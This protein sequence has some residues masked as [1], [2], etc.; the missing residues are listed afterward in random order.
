M[1]DVDAIEQHAPPAHVVEASDQRGQG[2]LSRAR[3][4]DERHRFTGADAQIQPAQQG[5]AFAIRKVDRFEPHF[6]AARRGELTR[7]QAALAVRLRRG[8]RMLGVA[9]RGPDRQQRLNQLR[10]HDRALK[11]GHRNAVMAQWPDQHQKVVVELHQLAHRHGA[12]RHPLA[13]EPQ[14]SDQ[15]E[16]RQ[17]FDQRHERRSRLVHA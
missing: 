15:A 10:R 2:G 13:A 8:Q 11:L 12:G 14:H 3:G 7:S 17:K 16:R 9:D 5:V 4:A 1:P 6:S